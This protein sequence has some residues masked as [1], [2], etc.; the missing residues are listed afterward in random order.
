MGIFNWTYY[1]DD[2]LTSM[3][4]G[5][6]YWVV[7]GLLVILVVAA[8]VVPGKTK[9]LPYLARELVLRSSRLA[10]LEGWLLLIWLFF[11]FEGV[12]YLSWRLWPAILVIYALVQ[13]GAMIKFAKVDFPRKRASK[14]S[15]QEKEKY[16]KKYL[17]KR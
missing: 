16:L 11:R 12:R 17:G 2:N 1:F 10:L 8:Y 4:W 14:I 9:K 15:G 5:W 6:G 13:I 3:F 7:L